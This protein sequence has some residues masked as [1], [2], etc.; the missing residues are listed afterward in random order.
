MITPRPYLK[1]KVWVLLSVLGK[2]SR[3][4]TIFPHN[5]TTQIEQKVAKKKKKNKLGT[6]L[7]IYVRMCYN[8][9]TVDFCGH[10][11]EMKDCEVFQYDLADKN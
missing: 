6:F 11:W 9:F 3:K 1:S 8:E 2:M 10:F 7:A 5:K 4:G